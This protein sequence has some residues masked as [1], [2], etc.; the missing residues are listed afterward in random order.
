M[1]KKTICRIAV[2]SSAVALSACNESSLPN[3][4]VAGDQGVPDEVLREVSAVFDQRFVEIDGSYYTVAA[5]GIEDRMSAMGEAMSAVMQQDFE[6]MQEVSERRHPT[7]LYKMELVEMK[8][9]KTRVTPAELTEADRLNGV[10]WRGKVEVIAETERWRTLDLKRPFDEMVGGEGLKVRLPWVAREVEWQLVATG[11]A[12][13]A[14]GDGQAAENPMVRALQ[15]PSDMLMKD[16]VSEMSPTGWADW[17]EDEGSFLTADVVLREGET[18]ISINYSPEA[19]LSGDRVYFRILG[20]GMMEMAA[21]SDFDELMMFL[22]PE[23][24]YLETSGVLGE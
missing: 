6:A 9:L 11:S 22:A 12:I 14:Q 1:M 19:M 2:L 15:A 17:I 8:G 5:S 23:P 13:A 18:T 3:V 4:E 7:I 16:L 10:E 21:F 24:A 20:G